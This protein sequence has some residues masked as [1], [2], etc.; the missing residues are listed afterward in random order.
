MPWRTTKV[1]EQRMEFVIAASRREKAF[2]ELCDEFQISCRTGY[3]WWNRY[4]AEGLG[5]MQERSRRPHYIPRRTPKRWNKASSNYGEKGQIGVRGKSG[6]CW[7]REASSCR[8]AP[9][10]ASF[11]VT[12]WSAIAISGR[13]QSSAL[14]EN[15]PISSGKWILKVRKDG[16]SSWVHCQCSMTTVA[17]LWPWRTPERRKAKLYR[18]YWS[19]LSVKMA[20]L[21]RC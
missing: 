17:T 3:T 7:R 14:N 6:I 12:I 16:T 11:C 10:I 8:R 15:V 21:R 5:G 13:R 18:Q 9:S 4:K 2:N 19:G 20:C 1:P